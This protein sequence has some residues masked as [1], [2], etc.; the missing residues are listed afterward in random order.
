VILAEELLCR[1]RQRICSYSSEASWRHRPIIIYYYRPI[2]SGAVM[3]F[4]SVIR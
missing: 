1:W 3:S 4:S 2:L